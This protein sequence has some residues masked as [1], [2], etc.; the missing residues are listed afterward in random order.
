MTVKEV[1]DRMTAAEMIEWLAHDE[2]TAMDRKQAERE[3]ES[4]ARSRGRR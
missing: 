1:G 4:K 2:I 3:A